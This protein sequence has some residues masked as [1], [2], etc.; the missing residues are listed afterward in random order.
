MFVESLYLAWGR[1][2]QWTSRWKNGKS[3]QQDMTSRGEGRGKESIASVV[4]IEAG[5]HNECEDMASR[6]ERDP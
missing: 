1:A 4:G 6:G 2:F 3:H 5:R